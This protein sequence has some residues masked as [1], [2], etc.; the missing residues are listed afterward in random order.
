MYP[1]DTIGAFRVTEPADTYIYDIVP[2]AA[3]LATI[4]SDDSLRLLDPLALDRPPLTSV[5]RV[6]T[7]VTCLKGF[8][9]GADGN[10]VVVCTAGRDGRAC[11]IDPRSGSKVAEVT[12]EQNAPILSLACSYPH[13][14]AAGSEL[15]NHQASVLLWDTRSLAQPVVQYI[16]SHSDDVTEL[17]FHP[18]RPQILLSGSTDG[19]VN[20]YNTTISDEEEALHQTINHGASIHHAN[21]LSDVD[22]FALSHDEKFSMYELVTNPEEG[23]EEP[24]P[25]HFGDVRELF[26]GEYAANVLRRPDGSAVLGIGTHSQESFDLIHFKNGPPWTFMPESKATLIGAH[27][28]EIVRAFCFLDEHKAVLTAGEDGQVKAWRGE[29]VAL[30]GTEQVETALV[31]LHHFEHSNPRPVRKPSGLLGTA[32]QYLW[33]IL[34][35]LY[36]QG[37]PSDGPPGKHNKELPKPVSGAVQLLEEAARVN[38]SDAIYILAQMN[39]YG[40]FTYPKD[41]SEA[42]KWYQQLATLNGNSSAQHMVGFMYATGIGGAV[43]Q[44]QARALLYHTIAARGGSVRSEM[45]VAFRHHSGIGTARNCDLAMKH[46][47][48]VAAKAIEWFRSGPPGGMTWVPDAYRLADEDG[49]VY[50]EGASFSSAGSNAN[51][52]GL[53][54]DTHA[55]LDDVLEYL[56]LMSRKGDFKA[57]FS[58]GRIHYDGQKGLPQNL[59][60]AKWYFMKVAKLYWQRDGRVVE[61]DKPG[62]EKMATKAAGYL[63]RMFLRGEGVEKS[64][65]KAQVWFQR[66]IKSGD[67]GSQYGLG[68]MYLNGLGVEKNTVRATEFFKASADQDYAPAMVS[69]GALYLDQGTSSDIAVATRYFELAARYGHIESLYYLAELIGQG[70]GRD[71]SCGL[72]TAYYK[73]IAEKAEPL[74]SSFAEANQAYE[75]GDFGLALVGYLHAAEQGY[76][77]GQ[78]NVAYLLDE[79]KS[80]WALPSWLSLPMPR[81]ASLQNTALALIYW[82]RSAKQ[83]NIDSMVKMG[84][85]YLYGTGTSPDMQKAASCYQAASEFHQSAQALYNLGWMHENGVGLDQDFHLAKRFYDQA[86]ET[87]DEAYLPVKLSLLKLRL[88]SAWNTFTHGRINSIQDEPAPKKQWSVGEWISNFLRDDHP[89]YG[90][91]YDDN[92]LPENDPMPGGDADGLYDDIIEDG[93]VESLIIIGLA[94]TLVFLIYYRQQQQLAHRRAAGAQAGDQP[95]AQGQEQHPQQEDRGLFP[96]PGDPAFGQWVAGGVGH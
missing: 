11:L 39:F 25:T 92:L 37:P 14:L 23:V 47:K 13:S 64:Y 2:T 76:E 67:A 9:T 79:Q 12:M 32:S 19:L 7:D 3:G 83:T 91:D 34:P 38:N 61:T 51:K 53:S 70:I 50:G 89:Y 8:D 71:R 15:T 48:N 52:A 81:P 80:R 49:G 45:T 17:Q 22:I 88:R 96:R 68:L 84:D 43:E 60:S 63:G 46:Y 87:N 90:D 20:I 18:S 1:L 16:E 31:Y 26:G 5:S 75:D 58:L 42:F 44:N 30:W 24:P 93:I 27:G 65:E 94:A 78:A 28:S 77:K 4:S 82:T 33:A 55:A 73:N 74:V 62:L 69:L 56:D 66:G 95:G 29:C 57:T 10:S 72:A 6:N 85:Y 86:L 41:Y 21:F 54:S 36:T 35:K 59:K 40:N